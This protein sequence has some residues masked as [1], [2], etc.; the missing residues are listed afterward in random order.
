MKTIYAKRRSDLNAFWKAEASMAKIWKWQDFE[1]DGGKQAKRTRN[2]HKSRERLNHILSWGPC[3]KTFW[4]FVPHDIMF[5][6]YL[7]LII[8][9][10]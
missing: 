8:L 5:R 1:V 10:L 7:D 4:N 6:I 2:R 3:H 9:I